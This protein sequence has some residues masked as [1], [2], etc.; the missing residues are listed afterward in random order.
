MYIW[1]LSPLDQSFMMISLKLAVSVEAVSDNRAARL[2]G[3]GNKLV[4]S[5]TAHL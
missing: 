1:S 5:C 2:N 3:L 4:K